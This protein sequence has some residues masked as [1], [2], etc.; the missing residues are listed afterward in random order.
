MIQ[1]SFEGF[2]FFPSRTPYTRFFYAEKNVRRSVEN[3][4][5]KI[6]IREGK[7]KEQQKERR[8]GKNRQGDGKKFSFS[9]KSGNGIKASKEK[10]LNK[11]SLNSHSV[12]SP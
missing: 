3:Q 10:N 2:F 12:D 8:K 7:P 9:P 4:R 6:K 11:V 5:F 1:S